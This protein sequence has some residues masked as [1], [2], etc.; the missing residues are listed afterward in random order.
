MFATCTI[1]TDTAQ[2]LGVA[3][4]MIWWVVSPHTAPRLVAIGGCEVTRVAN[5]ER[6]L[7][8]TVIKQ[9]TQSYDIR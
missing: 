6:R 5:S 8:Q 3:E 4:R 1:T 9:K 2:V 7:G